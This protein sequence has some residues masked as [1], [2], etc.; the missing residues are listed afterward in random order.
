M[1]IILYNIKYYA[2]QHDFTMNILWDGLIKLTN[3][4]PQISVL[5][6]NT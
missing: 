6:I 3:V 2:M 5:V 4:L 1:N